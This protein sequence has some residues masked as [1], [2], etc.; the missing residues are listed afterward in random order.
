MDYEVIP[1]PN[2]RE[3]YA[4][5]R[6]KKTPDLQFILTKLGLPYSGNKD[7]LISR[8][9]E[10]FETTWVQYSEGQLSL[11]HLRGIYKSIRNPSLQDRVYSGHTTSRSTGV[12]HRASVGNLSTPMPT[13]DNQPIT[14]FLP[15]TVAITP[16]THNPPISRTTSKS[17]TAPNALSSNSNSRK[18]F[19]LSRHVPSVSQIR[20]SSSSFSNFASSSQMPTQTQTQ[21]LLPSTNYSHEAHYEFPASDSPFTVVDKTL[22]HIRTHQTKNKVSSLS[23]QISD[24]QSFH[25]G[26][27][28]VI[29]R[30]FDF[31]A[32]K[33][34]GVHAWPPD[35]VV[36]VNGQ[37]MNLN[38]KKA[39]ANK[40]HAVLPPDKPLDITPYLRH[41]KNSVDIIT[42]STIGKVLVAQLMNVVSVD[43]L[44]PRVKLTDHDVSYRKVLSSFGRGPSTSTSIFVEDEIVQT[45]STIS[46]VCPLVKTRVKIPVR[47]ETCKHIQFFDLRNY[48]AMNMRVSSWRCPCC[49]S[50]VEF[51]DLVVD[52]YFS[53]L[54]DKIGEGISEVTLDPEGNWVQQNGST[55]EVPT[56]K[57]SKAEALSDDDIVII[58]DVEPDFNPV[59]VEEGIGSQNPYFAD[60]RFSMSPPQHPILISTTKSEK[61]TTPPSKKT[62]NGGY[63]DR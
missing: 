37:H 20:S 11:E 33:V 15:R 9:I 3:F 38:I 14:G 51:K 61:A 41:G 53:N 57:K 23:I 13:W 49:S 47:G 21:I 43:N 12:P 18:S 36:T 39:P 34:C 40:P 31:K 17:G 45:S 1:Q 10:K 16:P 30:C 46:L 8:I 60:R 35:P 29:L 5:I 42:S 55:S 27:Q 4:F 32:G 19:L 63:C 58:D 56:P 62:T 52:S 25:N 48:L 22:S 26:T 28:K 24:T 54:I 7:L 59:K 50:R 44:I 6:G 2:D